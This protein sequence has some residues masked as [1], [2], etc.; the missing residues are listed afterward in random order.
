[1]KQ[2]K[3]NGQLIA[4]LVILGLGLLLG[5]QF[6]LDFRIY[7]L[8]RLWPLIVIVVGVVRLSSAETRRKRS[9]G[10]VLTVVGVWLLLNTLGILGLDWSES[11]PLLLILIGVAKMLIPDDCRRSSGLELILFGVWAFLNVFEVWGLHWSNSWPIALVIAG[12]F[13]IWK[14]L[15][16]RRA[17][18]SSEGE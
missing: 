8:H 3:R 2:V 9:G 7:G 18:N 17:A 15:T 16:E 14:A 10:L 5:L 1:M 12:L 4:G 13:I 11:W 6:L